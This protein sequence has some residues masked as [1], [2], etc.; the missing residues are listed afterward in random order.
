[1][2]KYNI[3]NYRYAFQPHPPVNQGEQANLKYSSGGGG[4]L[5][6]RV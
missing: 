1:M 3:P 5:G 4:G 2:R 6:E